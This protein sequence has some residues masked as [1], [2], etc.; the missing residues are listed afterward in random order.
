MRVI[1][2]YCDMLFNI[3]EPLEE[4]VETHG[5]CEDCFEIVSTQIKS[6]LLK[7]GVK[8]DEKN[9]YGF[10]GRATQTNETVR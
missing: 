3:K 8:N 7:G 1:C 9:L 4:D 5:I 10:N 6:E 2:S